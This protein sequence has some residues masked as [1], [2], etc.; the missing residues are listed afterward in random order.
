MSLLPSDLARQANKDR[1][2]VELEFLQCLASPNYLYELASK[3]YLDDPKFINYLDYLSYWRRPDYAQFIN[4]PT[5]L[6]HLSL[7]SSSPSFRQALKSYQFVDDMQKQELLGWDSSF[8]T[9]FREE[10][11]VVTEADKEKKIG[12]EVK[13]GTVGPA[14]ISAS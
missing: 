1:F 8:G 7:L 2:E 3:G 6:H 5:A 12:E 14:S 11:H 13:S 4:Y 9:R 10:D